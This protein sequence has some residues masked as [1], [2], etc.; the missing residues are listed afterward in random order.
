MTLKAALPF[1]LLLPSWAAA[2]PPRFAVEIPVLV[3]DH[4]GQPVLNLDRDQFRLRDDGLP[5]RITT[6][7]R[8]ARPV[9]LAVVVDVTDRD[10][11]AQVKR[12]A[13]LLTAMVMGAAGE[14]SVYVSGPNPR[15]VLPFTHDQDKVASVLQHLQL[16][17]TPPLDHGQVT[18]PASQAL[19]DL[20]HRPAADARAVLIIGKHAASRS[21]AATALF[22][23]ALQQ[24]IAI[25][26]LAPQRPDGAAPYLNPDLP[27]RRGTGQGSQRVPQLPVLAAGRGTS[28]QAPTDQATVNLLPL[29]KT[30]LG[31]AAKVVAPHLRDYVYDSGGVTLQG[32]SDA[33]FDRKLSSIGADL[34]SYYY[35]GYQPND[36]AT[37]GPRHRISVQVQPLD[38]GPSYGQLLF[39][40]AYL[41]APP[42]KP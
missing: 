2:P 9:S 12:S 13:L 24:P 27:S 11:I 14:A 22:A 37:A 26:R 3:L 21:P 1:L 20:T 36:L 33:D 32:G 28:A 7:D 29:P 19:L 40:R 17:P 10:A 23:G 42:P 15:Q 38:G 6:F 34:R 4:H 30:A 18:E 35:L 41:V 39:R 5:Q 25:F 31:L 8:A 16:S